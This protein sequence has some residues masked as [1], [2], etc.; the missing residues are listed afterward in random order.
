M[1]R[2]SAKRIITVVPDGNVDEK[3]FGSPHI[4]I[5]DR[6]SILDIHDHLKM[7]LLNHSGIFDEHMNQIIVVYEK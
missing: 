4:H 6:R 7:K 1:K 2:V 3:N 5:F